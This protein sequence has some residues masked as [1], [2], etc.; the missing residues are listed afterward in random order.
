MTEKIERQYVVP[1]RRACVKTCRYLR[2]KKAMR[3]IREFMK[4]HMKSDDIKLG[5]ELNE[6]IWSR[7]GQT[8]PG[9]V[10]LTALKEDEKVYVNLVG[11]PLKKE[12]KEE[13]KKETKK[14]EKTEEVKEEVKEPEKKEEK[15]ETKSVKKRV[16]KKSKEEK[17][18]KEV[19]TNE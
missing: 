10:T 12:K 2:A 9:K 18:N 15:N 19:E 13:E 5:M 4:R 1:L 11:K 16:T 14:E 17:V 7:G 3:I 6:L 8:I